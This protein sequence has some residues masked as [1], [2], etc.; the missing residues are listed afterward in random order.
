MKVP[1]THRPHW[2]LA[3]NPQYAGRTPTLVT[4]ECH[5]GSPFLTVSCPRCGGENHLHETQFDGLGVEV[6][7]IG[8]R[9]A[10]CLRYTDMPL[11][12]IQTA[13]A[14]MREAGWIA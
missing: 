10:A 4:A 11:A 13:F 12:F 6:L 14:E 5:D 7:V 3:E 2:R 8:M 1:G 9:C